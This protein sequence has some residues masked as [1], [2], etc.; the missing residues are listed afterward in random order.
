MGLG[1]S[2]KMTTP[3]HYR[4]PLTAELARQSDITFA[5]IL[6][7][8]VSELFD[9]KIFTAERTA[10]LA[11]MMQA[12]GAIVT[13]DGSS[14]PFSETLRGEQPPAF[15]RCTRRRIGLQRRSG[16]YSQ[17]SNAKRRKVLSRRL[18][19][20]RCLRVFQEWSL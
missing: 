7:D 20:I 5:G 15:L 2:M 18:L 9:D 14:M 6:A 4:C 3:H 17:S 19:R 11:A 12:D 8:G 10:H 16:R 13:A 1:P